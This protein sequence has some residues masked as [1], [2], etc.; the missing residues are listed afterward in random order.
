VLP[1]DFT[2]KNAESKILSW[3]KKKEKEKRRR[4]ERSIY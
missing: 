4:E 1:R 3:T 2:K